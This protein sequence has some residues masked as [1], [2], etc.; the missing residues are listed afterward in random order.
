MSK[1]VRIGRVVRIP[2]YLQL[3]LLFGI[4]IGAV[5]VLVLGVYSYA[6][7]TGDIEQRMVEGKLQLLLQTQMRV[8][9]AMKTLESSAVQYANSPQVTAA[10]NDRLSAEDFERVRNLYQGLYNLQTLPGITDGYLIGIQNDWAMNFVSFLR[11]EQV[12]FYKRLGQYA[13]HSSNLFWDISVDAEPADGADVD[14]SE[15]PRAIRMVHKL[16]IL[17][18]TS[19]P[20]GYLVIE[21]EKTHFSTLLTSENG[22]LN[23]IYVLER[24]GRSF[25]PNRL[26][27]A[28]SAVNAR[29]AEAAAE[30]GGKPGFITGRAD[31]R[32]TVFTYRQSAYNGWIYV[33]AFSIGEIS[34]QSGKIAV[35]TAVACGIVLVIVG[36]IAAVA[37]RR[38]YS[39]IKRLI[40]MTGSVSAPEGGSRDEFVSIEQRFRALF[41]TGEQLQRQ[42]QGQFGQLAEFLMLKLF[43]G[44]VSDSEFHSRGRMFGF[45]SGWRRL[46]VLVLQIDSLQDTRY[47]ESD[48]DL[49]LFAINNIVG[50]LLPADRRF[51]P[52]L[53]GDSQLTMIASEREDEAELREEFFRYAASIQSKVAELLQIPVSIGI[54]RPFSRPCDAR[55]ASREGLE[56]LKS[57][58]HLGPGMLLHLDD[59]SAGHSE[60]AA[61]AYT[62]LRWNEDQLVQA[63][64]AGDAASALQIFDAYMTEMA[65]RGIAVQEYPILLM[66]FVS[67]LCRIVQEQGGSAHRVLGGGVSYERLMKLGTPASIR[68][69]FKDELLE[70]IVAF[71][72]K[73]A[74]T[75]YVNIANQVI[76]LVEERYDQ[77][78]TLEWCAQK[79]NFH[80]VYLSRVFKRETGKTFSE[81]LAEYRMNLAKTWLD[82]TS[83]KISEISEKLNYSNT[84][85]F[86]RTFRK[87]VGTTPGQYRERNGAVQTD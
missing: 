83:L 1:R 76:K 34:G 11:P 85:A 64:K 47:R 19:Q 82:T 73:Q 10:I 55:R 79:L 28:N 32:E 74:E 66:Q 40:E 61:A 42:M 63:L 16:P 84:T 33:S 56:A 25:L 86:I 3:L 77:D 13:S 29:I 41:S 17:P 75:Q 54:S 14:A 81:Y 57:R 53:Q 59:V 26:A 37:S 70:P 65:E 43:A 80:P 62:H 12:P 46:G 20:K 2:R 30:S 67:R 9:Q 60:V 50:E 36:L 71:L 44:Q 69:W 7:A 24:N 78:L 72:G 38:M 4:V 68:A 5:P 21:M 31:G 49:L 18:Y 51:S 87:V 52:V 48:R 39:P 27:E 6:S 15:A 8:E 58:L 45:P 22:E 35:A 23:D